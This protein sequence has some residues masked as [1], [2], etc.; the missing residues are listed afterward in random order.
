MAT[1]SLGKIAFKWRS[2]YNSGTT[3]MKQD[4]VAY[5]GDS[6]VC[7]VD[8]TVGIAPS[9]ASAN[10][11][12]FA[13]GTAG[14]STSSGE[15]IY[16]NGSGLTA[17]PAGTAGQVLTVGAGGLPVW[18]TPQVRSGTKVA[19]LAENATGIQ[20]NSYRKM[21][22]IMSDGSIRAWGQQTNYLLGDGTTYT[23]SY[24]VRTAFPPGF[25]GA[26]KI[27]YGYDEQAAC[28]D[29]NGQLWVWGN[30]PYGSTGNGTTTVVRVPYNASA[31]AANSIYGKTVIQVALPCGVQQFPSTVVLC[32][33]GTVHSAG[34]NAY[35]QL[36]VG[37]TTS[38]SRFAQLP[39]LANVTQIA[40]GREAYTSYYAVTS[41]GALYSWGYNGD[42]QLGDGGTTNSTIPMQ[43]TGG[44][45][46]GKTITKVFGG[47]NYAMAIDSAGN[48][49]AWGTNNYGQLGNGTLSNQFTPVQSVTGGVSDVYIGQYDYPISYIKKTDNSLWACGY[50][51]Y[52]AN[53]VTPAGTNTG[54]FTQ[55]TF[56]GVGIQKA[57]HGGSGTYNFG[58]ALLTNGTVRVWGYNGNGAL[59]LGDTTTRTNATNSMLTGNRVVTDICAYGGGSEQGIL[60]LLDD[61]QLFAVGYAGGAQLPEDDSETSYTPMPVLF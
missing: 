56:G 2:T 24:P 44:S 1:V 41:T 20:P 48:L 7:A 27:Y 16:N 55:I 45:L 35:G 12:I 36:G 40:A 58:A 49:H 5:N 23:R 52:W 30:N 9:D 32:S 59:G 38:A 43:R 34:Y 4:V 3:Y 11:D 18:A 13:Q 53:G 46:A 29:N 31:D 10:W 21:G 51:E 54:T 28:I 33:D 17:L 39:V 61:G 6:F 50:G 57:I 37:S 26:S 15:I 60:M 42:G 14:V 19:K 8:N 25:P 47:P 22:V